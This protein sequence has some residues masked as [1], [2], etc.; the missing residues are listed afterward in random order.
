MNGGS[1]WESNPPARLF[2]RHTGF[3]VREGHQYPF[4]FHSAAV[5]NYTT[6]V[7]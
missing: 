1:A 5:L 7:L 6:E 3:E 4:H 2:T